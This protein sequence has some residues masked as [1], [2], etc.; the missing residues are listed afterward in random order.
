MALRLYVELGLLA[1]VHELDAVALILEGATVVALK[2][3]PA[4]LLAVVLVPSGGLLLAEVDVAYSPETGVIRDDEWGRADV[5]CGMR[6]DERRPVRV[7]AHRAACVEDRARGS[8][9][10]GNE[11]RAVV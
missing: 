3:H 11:A 5:P 8:V 6:G 1:G 2:V 4:A 7:A 9:V 10:R